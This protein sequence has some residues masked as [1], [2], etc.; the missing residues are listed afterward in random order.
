MLCDKNKDMRFFD[1]TMSCGIH[2]CKRVSSW[3]LMGHSFSMTFAL[4]FPRKLFYKIYTYM[5]LK[6]PIIGKPLFLNKV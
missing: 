3:E 5:A 2:N 4:F 1:K 6:T